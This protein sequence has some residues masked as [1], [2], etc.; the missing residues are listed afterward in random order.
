MKELL[1]G[2]TDG[3]KRYTTYRVQYLLMPPK[4]VQT[5]FL[6]PNATKRA[7]QGT[8]IEEGCTHWFA[9]ADLAITSG[10]LL[11]RIFS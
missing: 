11:I 4:R 8:K 6:M 1:L 5:T 2:V 10:R 9:T 3:N 7:Q